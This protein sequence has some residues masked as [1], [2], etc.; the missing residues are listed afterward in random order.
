MIQ[1]KYRH[2]S[3]FYEIG[4]Y[5]LEQD[6]TDHGIRKTPYL[7]FS[8]VYYVPLAVLVLVS[9]KGPSVASYDKQVLF[10]GPYRVI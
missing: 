7:K 10:R 9:Y 8:R 6:C 5:Y 3:P 4:Q 2:I 1:R